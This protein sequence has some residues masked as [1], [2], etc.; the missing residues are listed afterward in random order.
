MAKRRARYDTLDMCYTA[1][2]GLAL[3]L[4][5]GLASV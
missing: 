2:L 4:G 1:L 5:L 3:G